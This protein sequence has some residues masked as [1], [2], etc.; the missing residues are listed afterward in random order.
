MPNGS[1]RTMNRLTLSR[2]PDKALPEHVLLSG[3]RFSVRPDFRTVLTLL[4]LMDDSE[5]EDRHKGLKLIERFY[6]DCPPAALA[7]DA[8]R[9]FFDFIRGPE[10]QSDP[11]AGKIDYEFDA[12]AIYASFRMQYGIDLLD[13]GTRLHWY[14]FTALL[15]GLGEG[16]PLVERLRLRTLDTRKLKGKAKRSAEIAKRN[17][18]PPARESQREQARH[19]AL[20]EALMNGGDAN[21]LLGHEAR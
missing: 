21:A 8:L 16:T 20:T 19:N 15:S 10:R 6:A 7:P 5:I 3:E 18:Q 17:A 1:A 11:E 14:A 4:R 12:D 9:A 13:P 2:Q